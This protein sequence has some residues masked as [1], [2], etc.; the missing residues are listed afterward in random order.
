MK[1]KYR[2]WAVIRDDGSALAY[3]ARDYARSMAKIINKPV[4]RCTVVLDPP[5]RKGK[6]K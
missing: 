5:K 3:S 2:M 4:V 6:R 1:R